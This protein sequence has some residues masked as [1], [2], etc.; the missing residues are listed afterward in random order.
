MF[1]ETPLSA[2][3]TIS[4]GPGTNGQRRPSHADAAMLTQPLTFLALPP[5]EHIPRNG[6]VSPKGDED[7]GA[8][9]RPVGAEMLMNHQFRFRIEKVAEHIV[10]FRSAKV[11]VALT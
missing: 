2:R 11:R 5:L 7:D 8:C 1:D 3:L 10:A 6:I 4:R 9:L